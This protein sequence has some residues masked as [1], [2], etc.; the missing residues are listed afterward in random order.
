MAKGPAKSLG[1][2][3]PDILRRFL[4]NVV[5]GPDGC[6]LWTGYT[7]RGSPRFFCNGH[8]PARHIALLLA[9]KHRTRMIQRL[10]TSCGDA[11]CVAVAHIIPIP[12]AP[13]VPKYKRRV[14]TPEQREEIRTLRDRGMKLRD[15]AK[16]FRLNQSTVCA[17]AGPRR[18]AVAA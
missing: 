15:L 18:R 14:I 6:Q 12:K 5:E 13:A 2:R 4:T 7:N 3:R 11:K 8:R 17:I 16:K 10:T 9:G 1:E